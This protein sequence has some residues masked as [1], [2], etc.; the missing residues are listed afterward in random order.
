MLFANLLNLLPV[1]TELILKTSVL[2]W[3]LNSFFNLK[4]KVNLSI[5]LKLKSKQ[6]LDKFVYWL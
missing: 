6:R 3:I 4:L 1:V 2:N 5:G